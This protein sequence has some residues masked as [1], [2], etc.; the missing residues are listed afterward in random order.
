MKCLWG[1]FPVA[2]RQILINNF[3]GYLESLIIKSKI[4][5][6]SNFYL[7]NK[8]CVEFLSSFFSLKNF[9]GIKHK[10]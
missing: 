9:W 10:T 1:F 4:Y 7:A 2:D 3:V 5:S 8:V 6:D